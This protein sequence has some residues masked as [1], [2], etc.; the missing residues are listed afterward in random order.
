MKE[1]KIK[2]ENRKK[3][4]PI[5][6]S[7][8]TGDLSN[9]PKP[10]IKLGYTK[11]SVIERVVRKQVIESLP[12]ETY[13]QFN[14]RGGI[15]ELGNT[16]LLF[17]NFGA[18][19]VHH[20]YRNEFHN[21]GKQVTFTIKQSRYEDG[22]LLQTL[23]TPQDEAMYFKKTVLFFIRAN[24]RDKF[25]Y[26]GKA[27]YHRHKEK[28]DDLIDLILELT[29]FNDLVDHSANSDKEDGSTYMSIVA[30]QQI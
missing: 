12:D 1:K 13:L 25:M 30:S 10:G 18:G 6:V 3:R 15:I 16:F 19:R 17:V 2:I 9:L 14:R 8:L 23:L 11:D 29:E 21:E 26:C 27:A 20:K 28:E 24:T 4:S 5:A 7:M 22:E